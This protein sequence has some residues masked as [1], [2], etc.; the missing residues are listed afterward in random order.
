M[1][2]N[3]Q[4]HFE[5]GKENPMFGSIFKFVSDWVGGET[6]QPPPFRAQAAET[7]IE[8]QP[9]VEAAA[10]EKFICEWKKITHVDAFLEQVLC[11]SIVEES[12]DC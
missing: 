9:L 12:S 3:D 5:S 6:R 10:D 4:S 7:I 8:M 2:A 1:S 11:R